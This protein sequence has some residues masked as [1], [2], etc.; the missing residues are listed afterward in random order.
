MVAVI[1]ISVLDDAVAAVL[2]H[3]PPSAIEAADGSDGAGSRL[4]LA[5]VA[6]LRTTGV[7]AEVGNG[8]SPDGVKIEATANCKR[9]KS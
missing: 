9:A 8:A 3:L 4:A 2:N 7:V 5:G 1:L 6:K